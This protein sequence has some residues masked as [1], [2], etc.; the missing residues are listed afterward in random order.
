MSEVCPHC[1]QR[2]P[3]WTPEKRRAIHDE[4]FSKKRPTLKVLGTKYGVSAQMIWKI[5]QREH[6]RESHERSDIG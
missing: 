3:K 5:V 2:V 6:R 4:Y 1:G